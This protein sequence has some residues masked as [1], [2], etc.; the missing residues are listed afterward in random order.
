MYSPFA[1]LAHHL[2]STAWHHFTLFCPRF[3]HMQAGRFDNEVVGVEIKTRKGTT[4]VDKD[5]EHTNVIPDKV[6]NLRPAF[7]KDGECGRC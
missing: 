5:E 6:P 3:T 4:M 1:L 2:R 7:K